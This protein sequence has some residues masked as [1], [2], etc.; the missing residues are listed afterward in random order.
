MTVSCKRIAL[1]GF[2]AAGMGAFASSH[3]VELSS[4]S[5]QELYMRFCA[6]CHG[7]TGVGDGP[8]ASS[9]KGMTPDLTRIAKRQGGTFP[10]DRVQRIIDGRLTQPPH[11]SREMPV[12]G[13]EFLAA[14][15]DDA[16]T[17]RRSEELIVRLVE[18]LRSIQK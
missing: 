10:G 11:G 1:F 13:W 16:A 15:G 8:V 18:Y 6:S 5:G 3:A 14:D 4:Y 9:I 2:L 12:W 17:R 7:I